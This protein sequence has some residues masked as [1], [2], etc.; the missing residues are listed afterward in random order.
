M[1][2][3]AQIRLSIV[4]YTANLLRVPIRIDDDFWMKKSKRFGPH[5]WPK[6]LL[7]KIYK[8]VRSRS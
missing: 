5:R 7:D 2:N 1:T 4:H 3:L 6:E 8:M